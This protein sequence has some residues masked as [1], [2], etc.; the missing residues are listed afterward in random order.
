MF[1]LFRRRGRKERESVRIGVLVDRADF[2]GDSDWTAGTEISC[3]ED[4][5]ESA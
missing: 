1:C 4:A 3:A 5:A 2:V